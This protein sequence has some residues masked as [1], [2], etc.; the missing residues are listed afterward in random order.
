MR[1]QLPTAILIAIVILAHA[2]PLIIAQNPIITQQLHLQVYQDGAIHIQHSLVLNA[3]VPTVNTT[4][5]SGLYEHLMIVDENMSFLDYQISDNIVII[6]S[7]GAHIVTLAYDALDLTNKTHGIWTLRVDAPINVTLT[8]PVNT[9]IIDLS[10]VPLEI[11]SH[12][13]QTSLTL[14][15]GV[16]SV[17]YI[18]AT[19]APQEEVREFLDLVAAII[20][21]IQSR[22][23]DT[24][25][26]QALLDQA[27]TAFL[28]GDYQQA[29]L[30]GNQA[31][32]LALSLE[33]PTVSMTL[34]LIIVGGC[35]FGLVFAMLIRQRRRVDIDAILTRYPWLREDQKAVICY[36]AEHR[37]GVFEAELR[38][39]FHTP[40]SSM[41]RLIKKLVDA[42]LLTVTERQ[43]QNYITFRVPPPPEPNN[44]L[45][46]Q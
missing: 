39:V 41:W 19:L 10:I 40:K 1:R 4:L 38:E 34:I 2:C 13:G 27:E 46:E 12:E 25:P 37:G 28:Q 30:L 16:H 21:Q 17:S 26:A 24:S 11:V 45:Q 43:R 29:E 3:S 22:G 44:P 31:L 6:D 36:L 20:A 42:Q 32:T 5:L 23:I 18:V 33:T 8:F 35:G 7:L 14:P 15:M 9:T